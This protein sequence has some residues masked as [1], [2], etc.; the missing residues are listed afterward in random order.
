MNNALIGYT[1]FVGSTLLSQKNNFTDL[2]R[3]TNISDIVGKSFDTVVCAGASANKWIANG[4]P[5]TDLDNI[6]LLC[7]AIDTITAKTFVLISTVDVYKNPIGVDENTPITLDGLH[8]YGKNRFLLENFVRSKFENHLIIRLPGL[9]G[10]GLKKNIIYDLAHDKNVD[11]INGNSSYQYYPMDCLAT[12]IDMMLEKKLKLVNLATEPVS[13]AQI[14]S[15]IFNTTIGSLP[16]FTNYDMRT[17]HAG[18][19]YWYAREYVL[20]SIRAYRDSL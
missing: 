17:I 14:A 12:D 3:S 5:L 18:G 1:G 9:V 6:K 4:D 19:K 11:T 10:T 13:T 20:D 8:A 7:A 15:E 2:Y 16:A